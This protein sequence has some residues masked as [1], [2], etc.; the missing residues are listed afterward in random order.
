MDYALLRLARPV[1]AELVGRRAPA[2]RQVRG[3]VQAHNRRVKR[4]GGV[5][6]VACRLPS[7]SPWLNPIEPRWLHGKRAIVEP[8]RLLTG[9]EVETRVCRYY[10]CDQVEHLKQV[11]TVKKKTPKQKKV[12]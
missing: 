5:R 8:E 10:G 4:E 6:I 9:A 3:W 7:K 2:T 11:I 12:A 1:G